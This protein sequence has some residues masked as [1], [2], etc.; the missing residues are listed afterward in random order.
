MPEVTRSEGS[1]YDATAN[2]GPAR[3]AMTEL[4]RLQLDDLQARELVERMQRKVDK[5]E[6]HLESARESLAEAEEAA[7]AA[8]DALDAHTDLPENDEEAEDDE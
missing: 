2:G 5:C 6:R 8:K 7:E 4:H 1:A 3:Q